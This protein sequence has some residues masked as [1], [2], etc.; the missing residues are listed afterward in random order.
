MENLL[1]FNKIQSFF[2]TDLF[3]I[4][5]FTLSN[6]PLKKKVHNKG[7]LENNEK[8]T[9]INLLSLSLSLIY[10]YIYIYCGRSELASACWPAYN[11][12]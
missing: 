5:I 11:H 2:L 9:S 7:I 6:Y 3:A 4:N 1:A 10:I 8:W 12:N